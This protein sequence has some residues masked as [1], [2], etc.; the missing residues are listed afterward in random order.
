PLPPGPPARRHRPSRRTLHLLLPNRNLDPPQHRSFPHPL[1]RVTLPPLTCRSHSSFTKSLLVD[2]ETPNE[3][4]ASRFRR[5]APN[6]DVRASPTIPS[7]EARAPAGSRLPRPA[8]QTRR[9]KISRC[10][11]PR[12]L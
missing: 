7:A 11:P 6:A 3:I 12:S 8:P 4:F 5:A 9:R 1:A 2:P 10:H